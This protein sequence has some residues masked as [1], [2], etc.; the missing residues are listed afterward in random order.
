MQDKTQNGLQDFPLTASLE[1]S[2]PDSDG[3]MLSLSRQK[4]RTVLPK[5]RRRIPNFLFAGLLLVLGPET[6]AGFGFHRDGTLDKEAIDSV[7][8]GGEIHKIR[9]PLEAYCH[10]FPK[11]STRDDSIYV[12]KFLSVLY[13]TDSTKRAKAENYM[14][15]LLKLNP[16]IEL[17]D[18]YIPDEIEAIFKNVKASYLKQ[19][20]YM[21]E[22]DRL[23]N[24]KQGSTSRDSIPRVKTQAVS[25]PQKAFRT[26]MWWT[27]AGVGV[28]TAVVGTYFL[29]DKPPSSENKHVLGN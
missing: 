20:Q 8:F 10:S 2:A 19:Q 18:M 21:R 7:Y 11:N 16:S 29:L 27:A 24:K 26:W 4:E 22:Y 17:V 28:T 12:Y 13:A 5:G 15:Q 6:W 25:T 9:L 14:V 3:E 1:G 23:G